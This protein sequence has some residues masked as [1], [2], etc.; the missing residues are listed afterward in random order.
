VPCDFVRG[1][2]QREALANLAGLGWEGDPDAMRE[3]RQ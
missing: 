2:R 1:Y 3:G